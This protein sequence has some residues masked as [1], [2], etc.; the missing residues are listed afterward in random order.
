M[1][2][3]FL[4]RAILAVILISINASL[5]GTFTIFR[6]A[7]FLVAGAAHAALAGAALAIVVEEAGFH[8]PVLLGG[9]IFAVAT[10]ITA[11]YASGKGK[12]SGTEDTNTAIAVS[13][14][15]SMSLAVLFISMI[16]EYA[17]R[18]WGLLIGDLF[19]LSYSDL[20]LMFASTL[21]VVLVS[22][23][24]HRAFLFISFDA[25]AAMAYGVNVRLY[26]YI[27]LSTV[28]VSVVVIM[29]G[30]GAIL[31]FA[32][33][34]APSATAAKIAGTVGSV[35]LLSFVISLICGLLGIYL[36]F[37]FPFSPGAIAALIAST[38]Y[39]ASIFV[40]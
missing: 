39:F 16:R 5:A 26:D 11:G 31:V 20:K 10:A 34:V 6:D 2:P 22:V 21:F 24:F 9:L 36:S 7:S 17:A 25:E 37:N 28:A 13:F 29:G 40:K 8:V 3:P 35:F 23:I 30:V 15:L 33:F 32:M 38:T 1:L 19:L 18:V 12:L 14:A 27:M 4:E